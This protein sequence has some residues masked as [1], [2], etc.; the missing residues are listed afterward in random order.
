[1]K[2]TVRQKSKVIARVNRIKGQHEAISKAIDAEEDYYQ[3]VE[4]LSSCRGTLNGRMG[5]V[6]ED[7]SRDHIAN[8]ETKKSAKESGEELVGIIKIV[9]K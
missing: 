5:E 2:H 9:W 1:M 4:L 8:S 6:I 3:V 7:H